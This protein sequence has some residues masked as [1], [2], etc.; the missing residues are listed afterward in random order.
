MVTVTRDEARTQLAA[1]VD[2]TTA[3]PLLSDA[4]LDL[5]LTLALVVDAEG[6]IP[7]AEDYVETFDLYWAAAEATMIRYRRTAMTGGGI[8]EFTS[9]GATFKKSAGPDWLTLAAHWRSRS[10]LTA[11]G[12]L[13]VIEVDTPDPLM[14]RS[15]AYDGTKHLWADDALWH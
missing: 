8:T 14:P 10:P 13:G 4:D 2:A 12:G 1:M 9:E 7:G 15:A 5:A 6:R 11:A 3:T